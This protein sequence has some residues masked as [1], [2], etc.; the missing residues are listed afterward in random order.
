M[1]SGIIYVIRLG[2]QWRD[3]PMAYGPHKTLYNSFVRR[4]RMGV[5]VREGSPVTHGQLHRSAAP[6]SVC[7]GHGTFIVH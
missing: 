6:V 3:A 1:L 7:Q 4:S 5:S 2:L